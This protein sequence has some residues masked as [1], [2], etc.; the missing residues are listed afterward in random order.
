MATTAP[1]TIKASSTY[2]HEMADETA[3]GKP[4]AKDEQEGADSNQKL[5]VNQRFNLSLVR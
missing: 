2:D 4:R 1:N 3:L 5:V